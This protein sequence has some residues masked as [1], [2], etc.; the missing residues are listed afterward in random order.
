[1]Q[2]QK[3][4]IFEKLIQLLIV[5]IVSNGS[6]ALAET[7]ILF[8]GDSITAGLG[9]EI[10]DSYPSLIDGMLKKKGY[11]SI[12]IINGSISGSTTASALSRLNWYKKIKP[13]ILVLALGA[14]DGLRGLP[15]SGM[16]ENLDQT[17]RFALDSGMKVILAGMEVPPNYGPDYSL[18]FR[19]VYHTLA[20]RNDVILFPFLLQ[21]VGGIPE[22]NQADGIHPNREGHK[23]IADHAITYIL[24]LL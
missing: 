13:D 24:E 14:N 21:D 9:V 10:E 1:M 22:L 3:I 19:T 23:V 11:H 6:F 8:I 17:I 4:K 20:K 5:L 15:V 18:D 12:R 7:K 2:L 16:E